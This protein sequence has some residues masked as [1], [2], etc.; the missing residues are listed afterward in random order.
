MNLDIE[1]LDRSFKSTF[2]ENFIKSKKKKKK[3]KNTL[4][5]LRECAGWSAS[6]LF[7]IVKNSFSFRDI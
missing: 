3:K 6:L 4:N 2:K 5:S 1:S 7:L